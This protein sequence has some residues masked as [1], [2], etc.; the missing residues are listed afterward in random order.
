MFVTQNNTRPST[1][2]HL[3]SAT[4]LG[5][6]AQQVAPFGLLH[7]E[8]EKE[9]EKDATPSGADGGPPPL[10]GV[11]M[12][13]DSDLP[14]MR[15]AADVLE[16]FGVPYELT[17]VSA[18]R[19]PA[20]MTAYATVRNPETFGEEEESFLTLLCLALRFSSSLS[21]LFRLVVGFSFSFF[22]GG[23]GC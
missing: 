16:E 14:T 21:G 13:S 3:L 19:T 9:G 23:R 18:H 1:D 11:I 15:A 20:R 5:S 22:R 10:V 4:Y 7:G 8:D 12:G 6:I 2:P 17:I